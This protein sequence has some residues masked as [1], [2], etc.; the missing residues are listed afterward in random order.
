MQWDAEHYAREKSGWNPEEAMGIIEDFENQTAYYND[1]IP[2][3]DEYIEAVHSL[4]Y[5]YE[6][7]YSN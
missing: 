6:Y 5:F 1:F 4:Y 2:S 7:Y 3:V